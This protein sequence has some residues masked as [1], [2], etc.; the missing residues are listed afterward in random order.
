MQPTIDENDIIYLFNDNLSKNTVE[1]LNEKNKNN[2]IMKAV[3][4]ATTKHVI[5]S[6]IHRIDV[7]TDVII[8]SV[9]GNDLLQQAH[10][11]GETDKEEIKRVVTEARKTFYINYNNLLKS[12]VKTRIQ[13]VVF[14]IYF[15]NF[16]Y[17]EN[18]IFQ[19]AV[20]A[21]NGVIYYLC[22][23]YKASTININDVLNEASDFVNY[24]EPSTQGSKKLAD[25]IL[26]KVHRVNKFF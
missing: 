25:A 16:P 26:K 10:L 14:T 13:C 4:G 18:R 1:Y 19:Y 22:N 7:D 12:L 24:I 3:D 20:D 23:K 2:F 21:F 6:Q 5:S 8:V 9:G 17:P 11:L 15:G